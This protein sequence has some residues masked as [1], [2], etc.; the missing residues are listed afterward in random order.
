MEETNYWPLYK[1]NFTGRAITPIDS[2]N[3][4]MADIFREMGFRVADGPEKETEWHNF[5]A[6]NIPANHPARA[7]QDT[8]TKPTEGRELC[9]LADLCL[10]A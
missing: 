4:E 8:F 3:G 1:I 7:M 10:F 2:N 9:G 5:D 6:L